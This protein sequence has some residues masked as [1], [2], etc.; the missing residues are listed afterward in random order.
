[1]GGNG[2]QYMSDEDRRKQKE[3][4]GRNSPSE[5]VLNKLG[6]LRSAVPVQAPA[7]RG[8]ALPSH[9]CCGRPMDRIRGDRGGQIGCH[10]AALVRSTIPLTWTRHGMPYHLNELCQPGLMYRVVLELRS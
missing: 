9:L 2:D 1:M 5:S 10:T 6:S 3:E 8:W 7:V 4:A